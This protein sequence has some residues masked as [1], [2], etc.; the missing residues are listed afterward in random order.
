MSSVQERKLESNIEKISIEVEGRRKLSEHDGSSASFRI[1][2]AWERVVLRGR[3][4]RC[5]YFRRLP[6]TGA[7]VRG[8]PCRSSL[9][10]ASTLEVIFSCW[11]HQK[12]R[13]CHHCLV[14]LESQASTTDVIS[15][16]R[17]RLV[18]VWA[19]PKGTRAGKVV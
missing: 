9:L 8:L 17:A 18:G 16:P 4:Q 11:R 10:M 13:P 7:S 15:S 5:V 12:L 1:A 14:D 6:T 2:P 19:A 3:R